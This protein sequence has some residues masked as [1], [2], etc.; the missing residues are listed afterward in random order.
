MDSG[1]GGAPP[2]PSNRAKTQV[3]NDQ[4]GPD[5]DMDPDES[6]MNEVQKFA[7]AKK[8]IPSVSADSDSPPPLPASS[9]GAPKS[10]SAPA[11]SPVPAG[12]PT[13]AISGKQ[14]I[15]SDGEPIP[16]QDPW[17]PKNS[18]PG[19]HAELL[20]E[21][22]GMKGQAEF[23]QYD[24][25]LPKGNGSVPAEG[26][27]APLSGTVPG[28]VGRGGSMEGPATVGSIAA[29]LMLQSMPNGERPDVPGGSYEAN[30]ESKLSQVR[31][32]AAHAGQK[33]QFNPVAS[34]SGNTARLP[35]GVKGQAGVPGAPPMNRVNAGS[36]KDLMDHIQAQKDSND[37][38]AF[39]EE[40][41]RNFP[42]QINK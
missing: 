35:Q 31:P 27:D 18:N 42:D 28:P 2:G 19:R 8:K 33:V 20:D 32:P 9:R 5:S 23:S 22:P 16:Y 30:D 4:A 12:K 24:Q 14:Q 37:A 41:R 11:A 10:G 17:E 13:K 3:N 40:L 34:M 6:M 7:P 36:P 1:G 25:D 21:L 15:G 39:A 29:Q 26:V 38:Q